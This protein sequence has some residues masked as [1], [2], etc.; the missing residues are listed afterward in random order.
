MNR[1]LLGVHVI[2]SGYGESIILQM[3]NGS[4]GL[5]DCFSPVLKGKQAESSNPTLRF[6]RDVL[7]VSRLAFLAFTHPHEDH[8]RGLSHVLQEYEG[9]ID[10]IWIFDGFLS[11]HLTKF[12]QTLIHLEKL[13]PLEQILSEQPGTFSVELNKVLVQVKQQ[14]LDMQVTRLRRF[15]EFVPVDIKDE[16]VQCFFLGPDT[17]TAT[18]YENCLANSIQGVVDDSGNVLRRD[19]EPDEV[20]HNHASPA[21]VFQFGETQFVLGGDMEREGWTTILTEQDTATRSKQPAFWRPSLSPHFVKVSHH[22]STTGYSNGLYQ[23]FSKARTPVAALT[24]FVRGRNY[25]PS[26]DGVNHIAPLV[27]RLF[28]TNIGVLKKAKRDKEEAKSDEP[29]EKPREPKGI[30]VEWLTTIKEHPN[31]I[32]WCEGISYTTPDQ[33]SSTPPLKTPLGGVPFEWIEKLQADPARARFLNPAL[34]RTAT[35]TIPDD[36]PDRS[37]DSCRVSFFFDDKGNEIA[38]L[39]YVG[40]NAGP[41]PLP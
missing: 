4:V 17:Q 29:E 12:F 13:L 22:G 40:A 34:R 21:L 20:N 24:P 15:R 3:P 31:L 8:G 14:C 39:R 11:V 1:K 19:W 35:G 38:E 9:R 18:A 36:V 2:G 41:L 32:D 30:P 10:E 25:L 5:V 27:S 33:K 28:A 16:P 26:D 6:L 37:E 23:R 7:K